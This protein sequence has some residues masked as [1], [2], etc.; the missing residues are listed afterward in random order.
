[1]NVWWTS[2]G[3]SLAARG[4]RRSRAAL[5]RGECDRDASRL[6]RIP[7]RAWLLQIAVWGSISTACHAIEPYTCR[8]GIFPAEVASIRAAVVAA[9]VPHGVPLRDDGPG[10]PDDDACPVATR[11]AHGDRV[12][13]AQRADGWSCVW[14]LDGAPERAGWLPSAS[15]R[16]TEA[17]R[18]S[19]S[20]RAG[21]WAPAVRGEVWLRVRRAT[22][23]RLHVRGRATW[24]GGP[25]PTGQPVVHFGRFDG[26]ASPVD[27]SLVVTD[28]ECSVRL[29][30][31]AGHLVVHD[32]RAC[33]GMNVDFDGVYRRW[34]R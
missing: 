26:E 4:V 23:G 24:H 27:D 34:S 13:V 10:C 6:S 1:M 2:I 32:N 7:R 3:S 8:N 33:G 19:S 12:L 25:S 22:G 15:L 5:L 14:M 11:V 29:R 9:R 31:I 17:R 18:L 16:E 28:G 21:L 20:D 30:W